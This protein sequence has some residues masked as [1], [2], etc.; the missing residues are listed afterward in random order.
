MTATSGTTFSG[1]P[2]VI[3]ATFRVTPSCRPFRACKAA[4]M[5][6]A[7]AIALRPSWKARP[8]WADRPWT[9]IRQLA[10]RV[11]ERTG[12]SSPIQLVPYEEAYETGFEDFRRRVPSAAKIQAAI[13]WSPTTTLNETIDQI[14]AYQ[15][16][17]QAHG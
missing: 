2:P 11:R 8:A 4:A 13:G 12:S 5:I 6:A 9:T 15:Q 3:L 7:P 16:E 10:E 1:A 14:I 17:E